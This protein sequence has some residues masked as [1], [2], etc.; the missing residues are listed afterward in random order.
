MWENIENI[1]VQDKKCR[2]WQDSNLQS[3][4]PKSGALSIRPHDPGHGDR[5]GSGGMEQ[6]RGLQAGVQSAVCDSWGRETRHS[7]NNITILF[8]FL[9]LKHLFTRP[10]HN[11]YSYFCNICNRKQAQNIF[12]K[13]IRCRQDS[14]LCGETPLDFESNALTT[15]PRQLMVENSDISM[16]LTTPTP[17]LTYPIICH[18]ILCWMLIQWMKYKCE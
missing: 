6:S 12:G 18:P 15:R 2:S 11:C 1:Y 17:W 14:N 4:D 3:P 16:L 10:L 9:D 5:A 7:S 13:N 8:S